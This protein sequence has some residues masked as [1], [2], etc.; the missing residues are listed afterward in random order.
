MIKYMTSSGRLSLSCLLNPL[1]YIVNHQSAFMDVIEVPNGCSHFIF[2][3]V[4][5]QPL[6]CNRK[7]KSN[8]GPRW[9]F[10]RRSWLKIQWG[11]LVA[12]K[13]AHAHTCTCDP[14][15]Q[16]KKQNN[17]KASKVPTDFTVT[18]T[19]GSDSELEAL[20]TDGLTLEVQGHK[21]EF[22]HF[23]RLLQWGSRTSVTGIVITVSFT[24]FKHNYWG[25]CTRKFQAIS[26][27]SQDQPSDG[28][29][30]TYHLSYGRGQQD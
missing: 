5:V 21:T 11:H 19:S 30:E 29:T 20:W 2:T 25:R 28:K 8:K 26:L 22:C 23:D 15:G 17:I 24:H 3:K 9:W 1:T 16:R 6:E 4:W 27:D 14:V 12:R 13:H 10:N 18:L 7:Q